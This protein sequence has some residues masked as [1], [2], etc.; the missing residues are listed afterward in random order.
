MAAI[1]GTA[2][3][4]QTVNVYDYISWKDGLMQFDRE[5]L[6]NILTRLG[7]YYDKDIVCE[8]DIKEM[9]CSGKIV[10]FD[11]IE[12]VLETITHSTPIRY[13]ITDT[14]IHISKK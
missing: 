14:E 7:R 10:L 8:S 6:F 9:K 1:N 2:I 3:L 13:Q 5:P 11:D 4:T 12:N